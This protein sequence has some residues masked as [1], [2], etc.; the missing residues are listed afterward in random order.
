MICLPKSATIEHRRLGMTLSQATIGERLKEAR[1]SVQLSQEVVA[2]AIGLDRTALVKIEKGSRTVTGVELHR[3]ARLYRRD[4]AEFLEEETLQEDP[5]TTFG[6]ILGNASFDWSNQIS[7]NLEVL[8]EA[9]RLR[10]LLGDRIQVAPPHYQLSTPTSYQEAVEQ[11]KEVAVLE[12]ERLKLGSSPISD[13]ASLIAS[14]GIWT[15]AVPFPEDVSGLFIAHNRYGLA[16]FINQEHARVRRRFSYAHEYAHALVDRNRK[17]A[18]PTSKANRNDF[19]EKRANA[20]ASEFLIPAAGVYETLERMQ[21][22]NPSHASAWIW[23]AAADEAVHHEIRQD[24][25][26]HKISA[27][28]VALLAHEY[29]VSYDV[30]AIRLKDIDA[31]RKSRLDTLLKQKEQGMQL[32]RALK[33]LNQSAEDSGGKE[34]QPYL[35]RQLILLG[36]EALRRDKISTGRFR[37]VCDL[38]DIPYEDLMPVVMAGIEG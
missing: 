15:A 8:K 27:H 12:R 11:G 26:A 22:G 38:A 23:D 9:V 20:F 5:F 2:Q 25:T 33:M 31:I 6:R 17:Q 30:A 28:D 32:L 3:L 10:D 18:E 1:A 34:D 37:E 36:I 4:P 14:Q 13:L 29:Q 7:Q 24:P 35:I 21:K 19:I 16:I